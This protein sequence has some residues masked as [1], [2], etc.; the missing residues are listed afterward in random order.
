MSKS[1]VDNL[2][3]SEWNPAKRGSF[4]KSPATQGLPPT[5]SSTQEN[6][7]RGGNF[8]ELEQKLRNS[9]ALREGSEATHRTDES[10]KRKVPLETTSTREP[11]PKCQWEQEQ[12]LQCMRDNPDAVTNCQ[13][14]LD[15]IK[16][17]EKTDQLK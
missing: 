15:M 10:G 7:F 1:N 2:A 3:G 12:L 17:C 4:E 11:Y 8:Q 9:D 6:P 13:P 14:F 5:A 16:D